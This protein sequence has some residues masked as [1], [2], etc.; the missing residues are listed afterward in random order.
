MNIA[1][2]AMT[3]LLLLLLVLSG[4]LASTDLSGRQVSEEDDPDL[5][6][7]ELTVESHLMTREEMEAEKARVGVYDPDAYCISAAS[8]FAAGAVPPTEEQWEAMVGTQVVVDSVA[9]AQAAGDAVD[10]SE[11]EYFPPVGDQGSEIGSCAAWAEIYYSLG[12]LEAK[13]NDWTD[14]HTGNAEHLLSPTWAYNLQN[15]GT[16]LGSVIGNNAKVARD[17]GAATLAT[18]PLTTDFAYWGTA[19]AWREAPLHRAADFN[20]ITYSPSTMI[21]TIKARLAEGV[22]VVFGLDSK[23][24]S[25]TLAD[26]K[27]DGDNIL[28]SSEFGTPSMNHA[29]TIVGFN[30]SITEDNEKGVFKVVNS[31]GTDFGINGYYYITYEAFLKMVQN[32]PV[33]YVTD[34]EDYRPSLLAVWH[35]DTAPYRDAN[36]TISAIGTTGTVLERWP[37][38]EAG[39]GTRMPT[40]MCLDISELEGCLPGGDG[41]IGLSVAKSQTVTSDQGTLSSFKLERYQGMYIP[42]AASAISLQSPELETEKIIPCTAFNSL[43]AYPGVSVPDVLGVSAAKVSFSGTASWVGQIEGGEHVLQSGDVGDNDRSAVRVD[44]SSPGYVSFSWKVS[45]EEGCDHLQFYVNGVVQA[46]ISGST[47]WQVYHYDMIS[48]GYVEWRYVKNGDTSDGH[49][50]GWIKEIV[51]EQSDYVPDT[52]A[53]I[54]VAQVKG[55]LSAGG[56]WY[57]TAAEVTLTATD[58]DEGRGV[59]STQYRIDGAEWT[60]YTKPFSVSSDGEHIV[61]YYSTDRAENKEPTKTVAVNVDLTPP[62]STVDLRGT[63]GSSGRYNSSVNVSLSYNDAAGSDVDIVWYRVDGG[64]WRE[65]SGRFSIT[66]EGSHTIEHY[67]VDNVG[68]N[69]VSNTVRFWIDRTPPTTDL[70]IEGTMGNEG[71]YTTAVSAELT[72]SDPGGKVGRGVMYRIDGGEWQ[73]YFQKLVLDDQGEH[74]LEYYS[75]DAAGNSEAVQSFSYKVDTQAPVITPSITDG[76]SYAVSPSAISW[77]SGDEHSGENRTFAS[78]DGG[79]F[80]LLNSSSMQ[81]PELADGEHVLTIKVVDRAGNTA[82]KEVHFTIGEEQKSGGPMT[83]WPWMVVAIGAVAAVLGVFLT[84]R[85][86]RQV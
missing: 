58:G 20:I 25:A 21:S 15:K 80:V 44:I 8:G 79:E 23:A 67:A 70:G 46:E 49:D 29:N 22:P 45:S 16:N 54:T 40:F 52:D 13:D 57:V 11:S 6:A 19:A 18:A 31:W 56:D 43:P 63:M 55:T 64:S 77:S 24:F 26:S 61:E 60:I 73:L 41:K 14:T 65:Y 27:G 33:G 28:A 76:A 51:L 32:S 1:R 53:P 12:Y 81:L 78:L 38:I 10:L 47:T 42:G 4:V 82:I 37:F 85:R 62:S 83:M 36:I 7:S 9:S 2:K 84:V 69:E 30:E 59:K 35:F 71:W 34:R 74:L 17:I 50:C 86:K 68:H 39:R 72:A 5:P 66:A 75:V 3:F 48:S